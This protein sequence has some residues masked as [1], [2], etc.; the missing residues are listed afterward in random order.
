MRLLGQL[1]GTALSDEHR[2][3]GAAMS[4]VEIPE[5]AWE[6]QAISALDPQLPARLRAHWAARLRVEHRSSMV[7]AQLA[8][9]LFEAGAYLDEQVVMLRMAQD[10]LRHTGTCA[11]V[12]LA[13]GGSLEAPQPE[14]E[15]LARHA[16]VTPEERALRNVIF[17]T[18]ISEMVACARFVATLDHTTDPMMRGA[19]RVLLSDETLHGRFGFH[20][21]AARAEALREPAL[22]TSLYRFLV[23]AFAVAERELA[24]VPPWRASS[25]AER[26]YGLEDPEL[27]HEVF[28]QTLE[29]AVV[30][31]LEQH[32]IE[33]GAAWR[34]RRLLA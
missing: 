28:H 15:P 1:S 25:A 2:A 9:Q 27:A 31:G 7:F 30:P 32:G 24:P 19:L 20:Y 21:L 12:L 11:A 34:E 16:G 22:R 26:A 17:T 29:H 5:F 3:I 13:L 18:C 6:I 8:A 23:H 14:I 4:R 10:E 33:A